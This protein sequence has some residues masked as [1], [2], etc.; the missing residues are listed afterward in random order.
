MRCSALLA[1]A[2]LCLVPAAASAQAPASP[3]VGEVAFANSGAPAAQAAFLRGLAL[4]HNFEYPRA[5][6][7]FR[8]AQAADPG[9]AMAYWGEAMAHNHP[10]WFE[11]DAEQA[12]AVLA[13]LG[14]TRAERLAKAK[15]ERERAYLDAVETLY[16]EGSK[17]QRDFAYSGAMERLAKAFPSDVDAAAFHALSLL[18]LAHKGRD[19]GLYMRAAAVL[20]ELYP[21]N[22]RHPGVLHYLI[23]SYDDPAHA[24]LGLRAAERYGAVAPDAP[25]AL[26]MT[27]HIFLALGDW[28]RTIAAN[29]AATAAARTLR[30][31]EGKPPMQC[32]HG[33]EWLNYAYFQAGRPER[34]EAILNTCHAAA[35][36]QAQSPTNQW[37]LSRSYADKWVR[38][39]A[40]T[41]KRPAAPKLDLALEANAFDRFTFDYGEL[42]LARRD[43]A[44][45][46]RARAALEESAA[47]A[48]LDGEH[49]A[50]ASRQKIVLDQAAGLEAI[51]AGRRSEGL[52][53]LRKAAELEAATAP[54]FGPP[55]VEKP[56]FELLGEELLAAGRAAEA[57]DAFARA[58]KLAPGRRLSLAGYELASKGQPG[59]VS[60]ASAAPHKH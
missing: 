30:A 11:Q 33:Y 57:A 12:R 50:Y 2:T 55:L 56:S 47:A 39:V 28:N 17:E 18:G 27:S 34:S 1:A 16:G 22:Q 53:L 49:P 48:K 32:G 43:R 52:A 14:A 20:E 21:A 3:G 15:T 19:F 40:E 8:Q 24:P 26:H 5:I 51:A 6:D 54:E 23:H 29:E 60:T 7:A 37:A 25:H 38:H 41:G 46:G 58:L 9:F 45:I 31:K 36:K 4:L 44:A 42:L 35:L 59:S 10:V 13:R